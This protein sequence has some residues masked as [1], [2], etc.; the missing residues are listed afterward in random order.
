MMMIGDHYSPNRI[1]TGIWG[2]AQYAVV[3]IQQRTWT[4][5]KMHST[6]STAYGAVRESTVC[7]T[8]CRDFHLT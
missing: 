3:I 6:L 1:V 7:I 5:I 8:L 2:S 4:Y